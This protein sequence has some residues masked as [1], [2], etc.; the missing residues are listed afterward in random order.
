MQES[1][2]KRN[3]KK[4]PWRT[5]VKEAM[6]QAAKTEAKQRYGTA[7]PLFNY[8]WEHVTA[9]V[10]LAVKLAKLTGADGDVVEAAAWL[11]D[12]RKDAGPRHPEEGAKFALKLLPTTNFPKKKIAA[13]AKAI[14]QHMGLWRDEPLKNLEAQVLW[15]ADKLAK[16]GL[17]AAF[18]F[19]SLDIMKGNGRSTQTLIAK[20]RSNDWQRKT[21]ASM[22][23]KPAKRAAKARL[24]AFNKLW[25]Q[26]EAE[27]AGDD[28]R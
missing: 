28:L 18:H 20:G 15:D 7:V 11:H 12:I 6:R 25:D 10:T 26:L 21:V 2:K 24:K 17:T 3:K 13:V 9:V 22:H 23:S 1:K 14:E 8:R 16:I 19:T 4:K 5:T 27:L